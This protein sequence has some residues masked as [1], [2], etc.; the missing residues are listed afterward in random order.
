MRRFC[1]R[2]SLWL[3]GLITLATLG[4]TLWSAATVPAEFAAAGFG[5]AAAQG[6]LALK[7]LLDLLVWALIVA[8]LAL[9][10]LLLRGRPAGPAAATPVAAQDRREPHF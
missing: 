7:L 2:L 10:A 6:A 8:P 1:Y 5:Q 4:F 9:I 3:I